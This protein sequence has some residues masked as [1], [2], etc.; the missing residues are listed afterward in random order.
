MA[1]WP[2]C[3]CWASP[4]E[5]EPVV[6]RPEPLTSLAFA[7]YGDV[8]EAG[9]QASTS[10]N[11]G[12]TEKFADL[13]KIEMEGGRPTV[14]IFRAEPAS[15]PVLVRSLE[16]HRLGSQ[17]FVPLHGRPFPVVV[18]AERSP[19]AVRVFLSNGHQGVNLKP[20]TWHHYL[21]ALGEVSEFLVIDRGSDEPDC[22]EW[23][24]D[25]PLSIQ[26]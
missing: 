16:R 7:P 15:L 1:V 25:E 26:F 21:L 9:E 10:I 12:H 20:G 4:R 8:I 23:V 24:L 18:A 11:E 19:R 14:H 17:A 13:A 6:L 2:G 5:A 3:A 22:E